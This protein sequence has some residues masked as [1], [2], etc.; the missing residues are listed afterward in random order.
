MIMYALHQADTDQH[1]EQGGTAGGEERQCDTDNRQQ[2]EYHT[3]VDD[4]LYTDHREYA[5]AD[6]P[7]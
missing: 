6:H 4:R 3:D 2:S 1:G 7:A 5:D